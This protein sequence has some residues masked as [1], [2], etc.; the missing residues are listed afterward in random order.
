MA[1]RHV[2]RLDC[3][4]TVINPKF[5]I[6]APTQREFFSTTATFKPRLEA[7]YA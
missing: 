5:L 1:R 3:P 2:S 7:S 4:D 6:D